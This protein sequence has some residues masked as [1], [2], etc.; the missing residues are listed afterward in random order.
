MIMERFKTLLLK[1]LGIILA[2]IIAITPVISINSIN[3]D[4]FAYKTAN[5]QNA[6]VGRWEVVV[7]ER[8]G[9]Y[10]RNDATGEKIAAVFRYNEDNVIEHY[11]IV[12]YAAYLN[13]WSG[14]ADR[15]LFPYSAVYPAQSMI[16]DEKG[17][18]EQ[19]R[20]FQWYDYRETHVYQSEGMPI[21]VTP[22]FQGPCTI[23]FRSS[24]TVSEGFTPS[25]TMGGKVAAVVRAES[26][27]TW[28]VSASTETTVSGTWNVPSGWIGCIQF[29]PYN[30]V[31]AGNV[32]DIVKI[33][34]YYNETLLG[35]V[36]ASSPK[37]LS[38]GFAD[39][40]YRLHL[41]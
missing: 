21:K 32:Y 6:S 4:D 23:T 3:A 34:M 2:A 10:I 5:A 19:T 15:P 29:L 8:A 20:A 38:N 28:N 41:R 27:F 1:P 16:L 7:D 17:S 25:F 12:E 11:D 35:S 22:D 36:T 40:L 31:T 33:L 14:V 37:T 18:K 24:L 39:G 9:T 30:N 13:Q 26:S